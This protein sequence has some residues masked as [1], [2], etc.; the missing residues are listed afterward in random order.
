MA[1]LTGTASD[2]PWVAACALAT[3]GIAGLVLDRVAVVSRLSWLDATMCASS[4]AAVAVSVGA[5]ATTATAAAGV[6]GGVALSRW[7]PGW[8]VVVALV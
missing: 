2:W 8:P 3:A 1:E 4:S 7:R 5:D 6:I